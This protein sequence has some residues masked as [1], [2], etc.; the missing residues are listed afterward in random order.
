LAT[1]LDL[2]SRRILYGGYVVGE[3]GSP[4]ISIVMPV[5]NE[6]VA[7]GSVVDGFR[8]E[9][10]RNGIS[11][12]IVVVDNNSVDRTI[13]I[14]L[15]EG[16]TVIRE[17]RQ[18]YGYACMRGLREAKGDIVIL[19]E[20]DDT[21]DPRDIW[22]LIVYLEERDV[23]LVLG[24]RTTL[25]LV[26]DGAKMGWFLHWGNLFLAKLIQLQFWK[27]CRITDVGCTLRGIKRDALMKVVDKFREGGSCFSPEMI[28]LCLKIGLR[29]VEIPIRYR[30][31]K[32]QSKITA[33]WKKSTKVGLKM[34]KLILTQRFRKYRVFDAG[35]AS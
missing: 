5:F 29:P 18:G 26:E 15:S 35:N 28:I 16:A 3:K 32:G 7:I 14:A 33:D 27:R 20:G 6:E 10:E 11:F 12:E 34:M 8:R 4:K 25:E 31:R 17:S 1:I 21:F 19:T 23:D 22:K 30:K 9:L 24:T 13:E 2:E